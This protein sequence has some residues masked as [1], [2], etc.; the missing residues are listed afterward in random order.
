MNSQNWTDIVQT[1]FL[2][3]ALLFTGFEFRART[4]EQRFRNYLDSISGF[5]QLGVL[6]IE[7]PELHGLYNYS[8]INIESTYANLTPEQK[9]RVH[10]CDTI[11]ALCETVWVAGEEGW[12]SK[13]EWPYWQRW[14][15]E[16]KLSPEF[17]WTVDWL[18][19]NREYDEDFLA[20][21]KSAP[22]TSEP[23]AVS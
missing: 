17:R 5:V 1:V 20:S 8:P 15:D 22:P 16:L 9:A 7:R 13:D 11:I 21:L 10:Y 18:S 4:R 23:H 2:F 19:G 14:L 12:V 6:M 3:A